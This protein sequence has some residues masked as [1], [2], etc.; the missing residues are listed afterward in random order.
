MA[1]SSGSS[2]SSSSSS[3][4][5]RYTGSSSGS[6]L[7]KSQVSPPPPKSTPPPPKSTPPPLTTNPVKS[8]SEGGFLSSVVS[9]F[10]FGFGSSL[11]HRAVGSIFGSGNSTHTTHTETIHIPQ[12]VSSQN[13]P[14]IP[15]M[16]TSDYLVKPECKSFQEDY[17]MCV[18]NSLE[19]NKTDCDFSFNIFKDCE[20]DLKK[21]SE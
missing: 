11:A 1:R 9:G 19:T 13:I 4:Y 5:G 18:K 20:N 3:S 16:T 8:N 2:R 10:G 7:S 21:N 15:D 17:L 12:N 6:S 14:S